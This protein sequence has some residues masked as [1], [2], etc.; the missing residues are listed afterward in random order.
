[1]ITKRGWVIL[2]WTFLA[3]MANPARMFAERFGITNL[4]IPLRELFLYGLLAAT[5]PIM[6][7]FNRKGFAVSLFF[8]MIFVAVYI[9]ISALD[10]RHF[11]GLYYLRIYITPILFTVC[12][13][14]WIRFATKAEIVN[15]CRI[16]LWMNGLI[17]VGAVTL[18]VAMQI[19][20]SLSNIVF[21]INQLPWSWYIAGGFLRMGL[22]FAA[23]NNLGSYAALNVLFLLPLLIKGTGEVASKSFL[24]VMLFINILALTLTFS[25]SAMLTVLIGLT[26]ICMLPGVITQKRLIRIFVTILLG[27]LVVI[28]SLMVVDFFSNG[29]IEK[30]LFLNT[31]LRDPSMQGHYSSII[32]A[33]DN[34]DQYYLSGYP[35]GTVGPRAQLFTIDFYNVENSTLGIILDM[36][37]SCSVLFFVI[38]AL[39]VKEGYVGVAQLPVLVGFIINMQF[40]PYIFEPEIMGFFLFVYLIIGALQ[41]HSL[42][43][44]NKNSKSA[45]YQHPFHSRLFI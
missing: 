17:M 8:L 43:N 13:L 38:Y 30:W 37:L 4:S 26:L 6:D 40:L 21:G 15:V 28:V 19:N 39:L 16:L 20:P 41:T 35:R 14:A 32:N 22:P 33:L 3:I 25:R 9:S 24:V 45:Y 5:L 42:V 27:I 10:D 34:F 12:T 36:G 7:L 11:Q 31:S 23:P 29:A 1:M 2:F 44:L 18:Y